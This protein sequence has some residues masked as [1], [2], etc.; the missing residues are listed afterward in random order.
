MHRSPSPNFILGLEACLETPPPVLDGARIGLLMNQ[1]SVNARFRYAHHLLNE[2]Y[3]G[4]LVALFS[5]QHGLWSEDQDNMVE[6]PHGRDPELGL[7]VYS[8]YAERR[9][10]TPEM[11]AR[12]DALV[13]DLQDVGT[14]VYTY[15]WTITYCLEACAERHLPLV[16][17]DRPNPLG[18]Q[19]ARGPRLDAR[20]SSFV[21]RAEIPMAHGLTVGEL[22]RYLRRALRIDAVVHVVPMSGW[23]RRF[24]FPDTGRTWVP[25]SP[26]LPRF[27]GVLV[28]PGQ[29]L[30]EGTNLSE[31][32]GTTTPFEVFGAPFIDPG[33]LLGALGEFELEG[34]DFRPLRF[35]PTFHKWSSEVCGGLFLHVVDPLT[36]DPY[37][38]TLALLACVRSLWPEDFAWLEPPYEYEYEKMPID[39]LTGGEDVRRVIDSG[40]TR[41]HIDELTRLDET[42]WWTEV[43][44]FLLYE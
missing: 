43:G 30:I 35:R 10:P 7:P 28:Y 20:F 13:I 29:V 19:R 37:R 11:L 14:R 18:G 38:T 39:I 3:S 8:L 44:P 36:F 32:R 17:L 41:A 40:A 34:V 21:G 33:R 27:E 22:T 6:T 26:N 9:K 12:V 31:G 1:A 5:P 25:P 15:I 23:S 2:A 16:V 42:A 24:L 4:Q